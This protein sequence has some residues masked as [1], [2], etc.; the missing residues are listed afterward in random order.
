MENNTND[1]QKDV[2]AFIENVSE[3]VKSFDIELSV[4]IRMLRKKSKGQVAM[5]LSDEIKEYLDDMGTE[6]FAMDSTHLLYSEC[7]EG[8]KQNPSSS[9]SK[10]LKRIDWSE[11]TGILPIKALG[12]SKEGMI[13]FAAHGGS[14]DIRYMTFHDLKQCIPVNFANNKVDVW[15]ESIKSLDSSIK[16]KKSQNENKEFSIDNS[17]SLSGLVFANDDIKNK[18]LN[19]QT[20]VEE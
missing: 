19:K 6:V 3:Q 17:S 20:P 16:G 8:W 4:F 11:K 12:V 1:L 7:L 10:L 2:N 5:T 15:R 18:I 14:L 13:R 9:G